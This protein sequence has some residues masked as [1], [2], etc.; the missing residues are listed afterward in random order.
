MLQEAGGGGLAGRGKEVPLQHQP[1]GRRITRQKC[2]INGSNE[3]NAPMVVSANSRMARPNSGKERNT[4]TQDTSRACAATFTRKDLAPMGRGAASFIRRR[5][6]I[7]AAPCHRP[8]TTRLRS[9]RCRRPLQRPTFRMLS[10]PSWLEHSGASS[11]PRIPARCRITRPRAVRCEA[12]R[13]RCRA[14]HPYLL[15]TTAA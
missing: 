3:E 8:V 2:A 5:T 7:D 1:T 14:P 11:G 12:L 13:R 15:C 6:R 9:G 4:L 10:I